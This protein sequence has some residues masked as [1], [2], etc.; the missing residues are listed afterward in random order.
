MTSSVS[1][2]GA[3]AAPEGQPLRNEELFGPESLHLQ[4]RFD[5]RRLANRLVEHFVRPELSPEQA[6]FVT[7]CR[8]VFLATVNAAGQPECTY[9]GGRPGF[10][11]V[12]DNRTLVLPFYDGN[13]LFSTLGN[14]RATGRVGLFF[15]DFEEHYRLRVNGTAQVAEP[16][17]EADPG[18]LV[19]VTVTSE[20]VYDLCERYVHT[21]RFVQ[22]S[23]YCPA[24]GYQPPPAPYLAKPLYDGVRPGEPPPDVPGDSEGST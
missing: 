5:T 1:A 12:L 19:L 13:G 2:D 15:I 4:E 24:P 8:M 10:I 17:P 18:A 22:E 3:A 20:V 6:A 14:I 16:D 23:E 7:G 9:K 11:R 21:M